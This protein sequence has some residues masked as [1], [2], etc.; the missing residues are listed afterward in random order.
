MATAFAAMAI[1]GLI[2]VAL[3]WQLWTAGNPTDVVHLHFS[4]P[5][6]HRHLR[7]HGAGGQH[8]HALVSDDLHRRWP[9]A[10]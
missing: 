4:L 2:D 10:P 1:I 7:A 9:V 3:A 8:H 6:A 5:L